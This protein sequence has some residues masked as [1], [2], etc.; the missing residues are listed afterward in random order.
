VLYSGKSCSKVK[1]G[2]NLQPFFLAQDQTRC[3]AGNTITNMESR[4]PRL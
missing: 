1:I 4:K 2:E 3:M